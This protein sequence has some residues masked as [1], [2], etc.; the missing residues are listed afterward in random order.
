[1]AFIYLNSPF[2]RNQKR[3]FD[4][5]ETLQLLMKLWLRKSRQLMFLRRRQ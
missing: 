3:F 5:K 4:M 2:Y 1:M